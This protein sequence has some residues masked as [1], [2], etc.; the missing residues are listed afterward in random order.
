MK[1]PLKKSCHNCG[2]SVETTPG[3]FLASCDWRPF[4]TKNT[5]T[6]ETTTTPG[7]GY[8]HCQETTCTARHLELHP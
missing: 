3:L 1:K 4:T 8:T 2:R 6:G 7:C 5:A